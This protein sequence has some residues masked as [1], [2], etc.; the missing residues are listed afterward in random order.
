[1]F[2]RSFVIILREK[3][4]KNHLGGKA[5]Q[6]KK[7]EVYKVELYSVLSVFTCL[8]ESQTLVAVVVVVVSI[9]TEKGRG[10]N[11]GRQLC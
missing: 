5:K 4:E 2:K 10:S 3:D 6:E 8:A 9:Y 1:M 7:N 11:L